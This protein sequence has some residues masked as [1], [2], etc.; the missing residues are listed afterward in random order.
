MDNKKTP[1]KPPTFICENCDFK[2]SNKSK[3][4]RHLGTAKHK[5][6]KND[7]NITE[8]LYECICGN[9]YKYQSGL[10]KH[11]LLCKYKAPE[12]IK[13]EQLIEYIEKQQEEQ[14]RRDEEH[15]EQLEVLTE[16]ISEM[17][18]VINKINV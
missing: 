4:E 12:E 18:L 1:K 17:S 3:Y 9:K 5:M 13:E 10:C 8:K 16:K 15:K 2:S 11:K 6:I 7:K 14:K